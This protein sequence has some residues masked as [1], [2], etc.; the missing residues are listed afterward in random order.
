MLHYPFVSRLTHFSPAFFFGATPIA[1]AFSSL[2][3]YGVDKSL[4]GDLGK[5]KW[6]WYFI[7]EGSLTIFWG[8]LV[9]T[10]LPRL[11]EVIAKSGS[12][13]F[14]S[15]AEHAVLMQRT[16]NGRCSKLFGNVVANG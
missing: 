14:R 10:F 2:I 4:D 13:L 11:P 6:E 8:L 9:F 1:G 7:I 3:A 5:A 16:I 15:V 12:S